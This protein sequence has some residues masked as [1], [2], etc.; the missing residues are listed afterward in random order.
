MKQLISGSG[1]TK[2]CGASIA[3]LIT[4]AFSCT[5]DDNTAQI[6]GKWTGTTSIW[7]RTTYING[8]VASEGSDTT[9]WTKP[10]YDASLEFKSDS[11]AFIYIIPNYSMDF[12]GLKYVYTADRLKFSNNPFSFRSSNPRFGLYPTLPPTEKD[13]CSVIELTNS[14]MVLYDKD[15]INRNPLIVWQQWN[16]FVR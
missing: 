3:L 16:T 13:F 4:V 1:F 5:K 12:S 11:V 2:L 9:D 8:S 14:K 10:G 15:T 7:K 6:R